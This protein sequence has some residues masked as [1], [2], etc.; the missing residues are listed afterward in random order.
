M[1][2][3]KMGL[4]SG[5]SKY[6][7]GS[8]LRVHDNFIEVRGVVFQNVSISHSWQLA[9]LLTVL[10]RGEE[11]GVRAGLERKFD[12][13]AQDDAAAAAVGLVERHLRPAV[14]AANA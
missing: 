5:T 3:D 1:T 4:H 7:L 12:R 8:R 10:V 6:A 2:S 13:H 14:D 9:A 11:E